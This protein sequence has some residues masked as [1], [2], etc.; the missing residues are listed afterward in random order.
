MVIVGPE[1]AGFLGNLRSQPGPERSLG[2]A[3]A[4]EK[5]SGRKKDKGRFFQM[6]GKPPLGLDEMAG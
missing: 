1:S 2:H 3:G 4:A 5:K 6:H